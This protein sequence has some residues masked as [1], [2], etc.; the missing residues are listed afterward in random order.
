MYEI[1]RKTMKGGEKPDWLET[2]G[3]EEWHDKKFPAF[4]FCF[5]Y[6]KHGVG[7]ARNLKMEMWATTKTKTNKTGK[8]Q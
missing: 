1:N 8:G 5:I 3:P 2:L 7:E 6:P 4:S